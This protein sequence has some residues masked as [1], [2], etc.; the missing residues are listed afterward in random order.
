MIVIMTVTTPKATHIGWPVP[1]IRT[2][3]GPDVTHTPGQ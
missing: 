2:G 1:W 3:P